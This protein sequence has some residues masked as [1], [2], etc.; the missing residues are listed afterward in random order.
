MAHRGKVG[1][2]DD[3]TSFENAPGMVV[4]IPAHH[5]AELFP[6]VERRVAGVRADD[7]FAIFLDE[8]DEILLLL[9]AS[10]HLRRK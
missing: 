4:E 3:D 5:L 6:L 10:S 8:R 2:I 7:P 1:R 9:L